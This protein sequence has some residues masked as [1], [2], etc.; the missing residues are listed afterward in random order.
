MMRTNELIKVGRQF[1]VNLNNIVGIEWAD[2]SFNSDK[3][4]DVSIYTNDNCITRI[5]DEQ[6]FEIFIK[7]LNFFKSPSTGGTTIC[8]SL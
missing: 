7:E 4:F 2:N 1:V 3:Y 6:E 8:G 5:L